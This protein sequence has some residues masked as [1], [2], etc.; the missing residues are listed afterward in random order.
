MSEQFQHAQLAVAETVVARG[1]RPRQGA[2]PC[3]QPV[4]ELR[5]GHGLGAVGDRERDPRGALAPGRPAVLAE[6]GPA[7]GLQP[8][9]PVTRTAARPGE[10]QQGPADARGPVREVFGCGELRRRDPFGAAFGATPCLRPARGPV[11]GEERHQAARGPASHPEPLLGRTRRAA[12]PGGGAHPVRHPAVV[13]QFP[14]LGQ[15]VGDAAEARE[16]SGA[17]Q[18]EVVTALVQGVQEARYGRQ[19]RTGRIGV[20]GRTGE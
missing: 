20:P 11:H 17:E 10:P 19:R 3:R 1:R 8:G 9:V 6:R 18:S 14:D 5:I 16:G 13:E 4:A 2:G 15:G 12:Q 7:Q